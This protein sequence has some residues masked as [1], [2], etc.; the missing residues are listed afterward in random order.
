[1]TRI[2]VLLAALAACGGDDVND[3]G[4]DGNE[5]RPDSGD[6]IDFDGVPN[7]MDN[8]PSSSNGFQGNE[9]GDKFGDACDPC[10][11]IAN[12]TPPDGDMDGVADACDP[13][14]IM[15]GDK[16]AFFEGFHQG[17]PSGWDQVGTW[18]GSNDALTANVAGPGHFALIV[19]DR[20]RESVSAEITVTSTTGAASEVGVLDN[21]M[22]NGAPAIA[23]VI[24][25]APAVS[26]YDTSNPA[27]AQTT[28]FELT[29]GQTY[30]ITL[31]R[32]N[33]TY[34]CTAKNVAS[35]AT[36]TATK[37][38]TLNQT[39]YLSGLTINGANIRVKWLMIVESL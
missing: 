24:T 19:T 16:V 5:L 6:D 20:T 33:S 18:G 28:A 4:V 14:P 31:Q 30:Q 25:G 1:V 15:F 26:V 32:E 2:A 36:A 13:K 7:D 29:A 9:D 37:G 17:K 8:C 12:D 3:A 27:G 11:Q 21:K 39:P 10:P 34:T 35:N 38:F 23:C 22:Q